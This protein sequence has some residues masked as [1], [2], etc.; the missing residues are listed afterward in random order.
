MSK[1]KT[2]IQWTHMPGF[3]GATWNFIIGCLRKSAGCE[4]C[5]AERQ[6]HRGLSE[7]HKGLTKLTG[8]GPVWN[9]AYNVAE[10][11][12]DEP[13]RRTKPTMY[14]VN[15]LSDLFFEPIPFELIAASLGVMAASQRHVFQVLTKRPERA[16]E[17]FEWLDERVSERVAR[18]DE[19][20]RANI[21][22]DDHIVY[23][24]TLD[25]WRLYVLLDAARKRGLI[26][27]ADRADILHSRIPWPL[28]N[29]WLGV[30]VENQK[31]ADERVRVLRTLPSAVHWISQEP[32]LG[33]IEYRDDV[34]EWQ[35]LGPDENGEAKLLPPVRWVVVGGESGPGAR[36]FDVQWARDIVAQGERTDVSVFIKQMG[37]S[38]ID[39]NPD[40]G[41]SFMRFAGWKPDTT[42]VKL[43][44]RKGGDADE[45]PEELRV[46]DWPKAPAV[47]AERSTETLTAE[48]Y[49]EDRRMREKLGMAPN[50]KG[51]TNA[52][53]EGT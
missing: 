43:A 42:A 27:V 13:L 28:P 29:V 33:P 5:Y 39:S 46:R 20:L 40:T 14:F 44:H 32:Q 47:P 25:W 15:S 31:T 45:W 24:K 16:V 41:N 53:T 23:A 26:D 19:E 10:H 48:S 11:R 50:P 30:S 9:G 38:V 3:V 17:F 18:E 7:Q 2:K 1:A 52:T 51:P 21:H 6:V 37:A 8:H 36:P 4:N 22:P 34:F 35:P 49:N 12:L